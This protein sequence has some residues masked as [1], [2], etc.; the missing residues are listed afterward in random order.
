MNP[1]A[2]S[3]WRWQHHAELAST[4]DE[5]IQAARAGEP[6]RLA[7][8][9]DRQY[10]GR[11]S[12]GRSWIA[13][14]GNLNLSLLLRPEGARPDPGHW[15]MLAGV[16]LFEAMSAFTSDLVLKWPNDLLCRGAKLGGILIDSAVGPAGLSDWVV[17]GIGVNLAQAPCLPGRATACL[18]APAPPPVQVAKRLIEALDALDG[19]DIRRAWLAR[20]HPVGTPLCVQTAHGRVTA[21]F[22]GLT[23]A[24]ELLL[25]GV[26]APINSADVFV[27]R[28]SC[29]SS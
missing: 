14:E 18:E 27:A 2:P 1:T 12:R 9:A 19:R 7:I 21:G 10:A 23:L 17:I 29:C 13:P 25:E 16:A 28:T 22:A 24:G 26:L 4:Q 15:A 8:V 5:A 6:G 3:C 11:G 20:A